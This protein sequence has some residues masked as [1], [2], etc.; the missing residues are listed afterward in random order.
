[1][2]I[3]ERGRVLSNE[4]DGLVPRTNFYSCAGYGRGLALV[5]LM[6]MM[7]TWLSLQHFSKGRDNFSRG[8]NMP[9]IFPRGD[10]GGRGGGI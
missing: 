1:M 3:L 6:M 2:T 10:N 4:F 7:M 5:K 9:E 8:D